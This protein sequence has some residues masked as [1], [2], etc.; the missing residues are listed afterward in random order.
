MERDGLDVNINVLNSMTLLYANA[1]RA[2]Q[3]EAE[4]LPLYDKY[5]IKHDV[6]TYQNL[7]RLYLDLRELDTV[8]KLYDRLREKETFKPNQFLLNTLFETSLRLKDSDRIAMVLD[9]YVD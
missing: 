7:S 3:L 6:Y 1:L 2:E 8:M 9:D 4:V 5:K